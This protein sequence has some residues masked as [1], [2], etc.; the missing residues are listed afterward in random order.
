[1]EKT[2]SK[3]IGYSAEKPTDKV[4]EQTLDTF[5]AI[6]KKAMMTLITP[7]ER[8]VYMQKSEQV[9]KSDKWGKRTYKKVSLPIPKAITNI[10]PS[11]LK[12]GYNIDIQDNGQTITFTS[13]C[14]PVVD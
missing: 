5:D 12:T 14:R 11:I 6:T 8:F 10:Y 2:K 9:Y 4:V 1:M 3:A 7:H 13:G